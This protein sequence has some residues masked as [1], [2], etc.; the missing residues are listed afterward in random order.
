MGHICYNINIDRE[1]NT[2][3]INQK[4]TKTLNI[5]F[6]TQSTHLTSNPPFLLHLFNSPHPSSSFTPPFPSSFS[7]LT[8]FF[9]YYLFFYISLLIDITSHAGRQTQKYDNRLPVQNALLPQRIP[10]RR[11]T[12]HGKGKHTQG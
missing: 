4:H 11:G 8:L 5:S 3:S 9:R 12:R 2:K 6:N 10:R 7:L 1:P